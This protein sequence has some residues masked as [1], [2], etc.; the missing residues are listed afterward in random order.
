MAN[1]V[2]NDNFSSYTEKD[3]AT[4]SK[5]TI[6]KKMLIIGICS[7]C[8]FMLICILVGIL[9]GN[10]IARKH[11]INVQNTAN[12]IYTAPPSDKLGTGN[13]ALADVVSSISGSIVE[14][15]T[16][17]I[18]H[19]SAPE[20]VKHGAGSGVIFGSYLK[21]EA[22]AGYNIV[23]NLH[24]IQDKNRQAI[25]S[26]IKA[27]LNDGTEYNAVVVGYD[28]DYDIAILRINETKRNLTC[29]T[30]ATPNSIRAGDGVIAIGNPLTEVGSSATYGILSATERKIKVSTYST[31]MLM[32]ANVVVNPGNSGGGLFD[33]NGRLIGII[34]TEATVTDVNG[35]AF[36]TPAPLA[37]KL[38]TDIAQHGFVQN[39]PYIGVEFKR[40]LDGTVRVEELLD[41]Y[42]ENLLKRGDRVVSVN[43]NTVLNEDQIYELVKELK[44]GDA[45][46][47]VVLRDGTEIAVAIKVYN[48]HPN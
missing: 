10:A 4:Q 45:I 41:G 33:A 36:A 44:N 43:G 46:M 38:C 17:H 28:V 8:I 22:L 7:V 31:M 12:T 27:I 35:I 25:A 30:F 15:R 34:N 5:K 11:P 23:T 6:S 3:T 40:F 19:T 2:Y 18:S 29:A 26:S 37:Q 16:E 14:I 32:Q 47:L 48:Y 39:K 42:N 1:Y 24:V 20:A 21:N 9:I 13:L